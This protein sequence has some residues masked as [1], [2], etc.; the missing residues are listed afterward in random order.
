MLLRRPR[1]PGHSFYKLEK[2][3][4]GSSRRAEWSLGAWASS[5]WKSWEVVLACLPSSSNSL[6]P[7]TYHPSSGFDANHP[8]AHQV[9]LRPSSRTGRPRLRAA[10]SAVF[11]EH[12]AIQL[13]DRPAEELYAVVDTAG[14]EL[15]YL[16]REVFRTPGLISS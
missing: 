12:R 2:Q 9:S 14:M 15:Q 11:I 3:E 16:L 7:A 4:G 1:P 10:C 5:G 6:W 13:V 8:F